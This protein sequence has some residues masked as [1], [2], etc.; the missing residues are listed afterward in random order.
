MKEDLTK[1]TDAELEK[2]LKALKMSQIKASSVWGVN[3]I[4]NK[5]LGFSKGTA[6]K[7]VKTSLQKD[8]RRGIARVLT[9]M[10]RRSYNES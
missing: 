2:R 4:K 3:A 9:E 8:I 10:R 5:E 1:L 6:K 7:G